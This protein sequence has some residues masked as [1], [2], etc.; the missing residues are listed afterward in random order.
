MKAA[1]Y[2]K[3]GPARGTLIIDD[4][5]APVPQTGEVLV[6]VHASG[7]NPSDVKSRQGGRSAMPFPLIVPHSDG[8]GVI[9]AVGPDVP[10]ARIGE[11][12]W[13]HNAQW[14]RPFG[15]AS[16]LVS[17]PASLATPLSG[18]MSFEEGAC[19][20][21]PAMTA[22]RVVFADGEVGDQWVLVTG[23]AGNVAHYAIQF[24]K[25]GGARVIATVSSEAKAIH[26]KSAGADLILNYRADDVVAKVL[27][28]TD[29]AGVERVVDVDFGAN[30]ATSERLI[31]NNGTI[32]SYASAAVRDPALPFY[33][34]MYKNVTVRTVLVYSMPDEAKAAAIRAITRAQDEGALRHAIGGRFSLKEIATAHEAVEQGTKIGNVVVDVR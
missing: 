3:Q 23:G 32:A 1:F 24:A 13:L 17:V 18:K 7:V 19:L 21:I 26:A 31:R 30:L 28:A 9:S 10:K 11:R 16:E 5:P 25:W 34:L 15:T 2:R 8:A 20:G 4:L 14:Q 29:G 27:E 12:V 6:Q 33:T 22:H